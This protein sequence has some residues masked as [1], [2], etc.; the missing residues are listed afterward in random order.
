MIQLLNVSS[1]LVCIL[2]Q[3]DEEDDDPFEDEDLLSLQDLVTS[4]KA[5]CSAKEFVHCDDDLEVCPGLVDPSDPEWRAKVREEP[6]ASNEEDPQ[7]VN[8]TKMSR[9]DDEEDTVGEPEIKSDREALKMAEKLLEF[10]RFNG[11]EKLSLVL[12][13]TTD[14]LQ[15]IVI[16]NQKQS[17]IDN[18]FL[19]T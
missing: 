12:S 14:L 3:V 6:L 7:L 17:T 5:P 8:C 4:P 2:K 16:Q 9:G 19:R 11:K 15:E 13:K 10:S 1:V 18:F